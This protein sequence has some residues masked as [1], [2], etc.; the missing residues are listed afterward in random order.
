MSEEKNLTTTITEFILVGFPG[1]HP[2]YHKLM[3]FVL[4]LL[5]V[6]IVAA[7]TTYVVI[8][9]LK[10][11]LHKPMY[12]ILVSLALSDIGFSTA[13]LPKIIARYWFDDKV[14]A[15]HAC[16]M[17]RLFIHSFGSLNSFIMM[18]MAVDR[19]L[20][21]C[22]PLRYP[23][24]VKNRTMVIVNCWA[25]VF[26]LVPTGVSFIYLYMLPYCGPN[27][28]YQCY[29]DQNSI[30]KLACASQSWPTLISFCLAMLVLLIPLAFIVYSYLH[31]IVSVAKL[32]SSTGQWKTFST[33]STQMCIITIYY[34]PRCT[35]YALNLV[36]ISMNINLH[37]GVALIY[38]LLP[39]LVNPL[40]YC[41]RTKEIQE[42]LVRLIGFKW[43]G[44]RSVAAVS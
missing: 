25:W 26:S 24:L 37:I 8:F 12:I 43:V 30:L 15:F 9:S 18:I 5:Y 10:P 2:N 20:A 41:F 17:Q 14:I 35:V 36:G 4:C 31:I 28:I 34:L 32:K 44:K 23:V 40:I 13:A 1:L 21:I 22:F 42:T 38:S 33:C 16:F 7:N 6:S 39:P 11:S 3:G 29:C 19:Y 27:I